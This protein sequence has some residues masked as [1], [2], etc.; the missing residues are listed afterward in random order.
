MNIDTEICI[1][2]LSSISSVRLLQPHGPAR[3]LCPWDPSGKNTGVGCHLQGLSTWVLPAS[4]LA[5][6]SHIHRYLYL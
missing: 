4:L 2:S 6:L 1:C 3:L 5:C